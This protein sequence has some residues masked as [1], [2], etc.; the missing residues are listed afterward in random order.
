MKLSDALRSAADRAPV[1]DAT[2]AVGTVAGRVKRQRAVRAGSTGLVGAGAVAVL[3]FGAAGL[4]MAASDDSGDGAG[5]ESAEAPAMGESD[6]ATEESLGGA[7][8]DSRMAF[9]LCGDT[10][11][12]QEWGEPTV[13]LNTRIGSDEVEPGTYVEVS[14]DATALT[15]VDLLTGGPDY[16]VTWDGMVV[17][18]IHESPLFAYGPADELLENPDGLQ[19]VVLAEGESSTMTFEIDLVN[20]WDGEP[21]PAG[22]YEIYAWQSFAS[23]LSQPGETDT[24]PGAEPGTEPSRLSDELVGPT[25]DDSAASSDATVSSDSTVSSDQ[26]L[27]G[28]DDLP[29]VDVEHFRVAAAPVGFAVAGEPVDDPFA[30]YLTP[31][32]PE[33]KPAPAEPQPVPDGYLTPDEARA[34]F[35]QTRADSTWSMAAGS[36]RWVIAYDSRR[37]DEEQRWYGCSWGDESGSR[38]PTESAEMGLLDVSVDLPSAIS[39]S[40]GFVVDGNPE[41]TSE[42][43][44]VSDYSIPNF[45]ESAQPSLYLVR[46]G[47]VVAEGYPESIDRSGY[48]IERAMD[49]AAADEMSILPWPGGDGVFEPGEST[50]GRFLW[51]DVTGCAS[52]DGSGQVDSGTYTVLTMQSISLSNDGWMADGGVAEDVIAEEQA[53]ALDQEARDGDAVQLPA[54]ESPGIGG[55]V[56]GTTGGGSLDSMGS[57]DAAEPDIAIAPAPDMEYDWIDLQVWTS[58][59]TVTV[60]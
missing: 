30:A 4:P 38:F 7:A 54:I 26:D 29:F 39:V 51:R 5:L 6:M 24:E 22:K 43:S 49:E 44:N 11:Y 25:P 9:A 52:P 10:V 12:G 45:W 41:V 47:R 55:V 14:F 8:A 48:G 40:Y 2:V 59:G 35:D 19:S 3:A 42:I 60:R 32:R 36:Q 34:L 13:S 53:L 57:T 37:M 1:D 16:V 20:C 31:L 28:V 15:D 46:D 21:L 18:A 27:P 33:P 56:G 50:S 23:G 58:L 17:G